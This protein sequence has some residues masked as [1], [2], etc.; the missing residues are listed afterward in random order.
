MIRLDNRDNGMS[1]PTTDLPAVD[2]GAAIGALVAGEKLEAAP[3]T[4][5]DMADDVLAVLDDLGVERAHLAG[6]SMGGFIVHSA[7]LRHPERVASLTVVMSGSGAQPGDDGPQLNPTAVAQL[8][9]QTE[10]RVRESAIEFLVDKWRWL[11]G[12]GIRSM[13]H[14]FVNVSCRR[15]IAPTVRR[16]L[17]G[18]FSPECIR[19]ASGLPRPES[20]V[21]LW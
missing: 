3:Y 17:R 1:V 11:W 8:I 6:A 2:V 10:R 20:G 15:S 19:Q 9:A 7:A 16:V 14:G 21:Q 18:T 13:R 4:Y 12:T 5:L